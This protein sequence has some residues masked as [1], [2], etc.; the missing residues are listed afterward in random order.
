M[1]VK[2]SKPARDG[3]MGVGSRSPTQP[4]K[5]HKNPEAVPTAAEEDAFRE[6]LDERANTRT[7]LL[8]EILSCC[9]GGQAG[10]PVIRA[11]RLH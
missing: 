11:G 6:G 9:S 4:P 3:A 2:R 7:H 10:N 5:L 8:D 1:S